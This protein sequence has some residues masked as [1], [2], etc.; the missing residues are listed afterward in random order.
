MTS[1]E[2]MTLDTIT[3]V[4]IVSS[5]VQVEETETILIGMTVTV[6]MVALEETMTTIVVVIVTA[7]VGI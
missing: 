3:I 7:L 5:T 4:T 1:Q 2:T 6:H